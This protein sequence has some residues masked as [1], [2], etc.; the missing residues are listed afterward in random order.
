[1]AVII[2]GFSVVVRNS[3]LADKYPGGVEGYHRDCPNGTFCADESVS[4][5]GF[6]A[7]SDADRFVAEL[8]EKGLTPFRKNAAED[9]AL[10]S[11]VGG[12]L[13]PCSWLELG[14]WGQ[15]VIAWLAG[16]KAGDVHAPAGW[17]PQQGMQQ[18]SAEELK[19]RL[20]FARSEGNVDVYR[21]RTTG[22]EMYV[23]RTASSSDEAKARHG[24]LYKQ[25]CRLIEGLILLSN[26]EP[27]PLDP[28][29]RQ[30]LE[31]AIPLFIEVVAINPGNW[32]AMWMLG[33]VYQRLGEYQHGL[34]WFSRAHRVNSDQPDV[35]R[36]A[37]IAAM[38]LGRA[39]EAI[40]FC[41]RA[42][43]TNPDDAGLR[44]NLALAL[45]F[46]GKPGEARTVA[47][48][49]LARDPADKITAHI[50]RIIEE[51]VGGNRPCPHHVSDLR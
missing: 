9:A 17:S 44:A 51:V 39:E 21:D 47:Q 50:V 12:L 37:S 33:K 41:E 32:A 8:A 1:M 27:Q 30:R 26:E 13:R 46:S 19:R 18:M 22:Q 31:D 11:P 6:M 49:A 28:L 24:E 45:L 29:Q 38:D 14:R 34:T 15:V 10:V 40:P 7:R 35:A 42:I 48:E 2:E 4:R 23:G 20:E 36:E 43:E 25:A 3:T 5:V 16:T